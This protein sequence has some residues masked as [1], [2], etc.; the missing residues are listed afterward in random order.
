MFT[1][2]KRTL[3]AAAV[4]TAAIAPASAHAR[5]NLNPPVP[6]AVAT[7]ASTVS[8]ESTAPTAGTAAPS[9]GRSEAASAPGFRWD[10]AGIGAA[11]IVVLLGAGAR[12]AAV[13]ARRRGHSPRV[14]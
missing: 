12:S 5:L 4:T 14:G 10:D 9:A 8:T 1:V 6:N 11:G 13:I 3:A 7:A 2:S